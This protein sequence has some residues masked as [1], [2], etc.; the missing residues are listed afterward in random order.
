LK[1]QKMAILSDRRLVAAG[2]MLAFLLGGTAAGKVDGQTLS[3]KTLRTMARAY[4]AY[5]QYDKAQAL[6]EKAAIQSQKGQVE[7]GEQALCLIDL[8]TVYSYQD[9]LDDAAVMLAEGVRLQQQAIG[10][11]HPYTA[12]TLRMLSD[13]YRRQGNL[14]AAEDALGQ[15]FAVML[16]DTSIQSRQMTPFLM[17]A[18]QLCAAQGRYEAACMTFQVAEQMAIAAYGATHLYT[19]QVMQGA[20][21][22]A[23]ACGN[24]DYAQEQ[25]ERSVQIQERYWSN[26]PAMLIGGWLSKARISRACGALGESELYLRK[27]IAAAQQG[28]NVVALAGVYKQVNAIRAETLYTA[29][30]Q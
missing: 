27:A 25:I 14:S 19:A 6:A 15:A 5:G 18:A 3:T 9:M 7:L 28:R 10:A 4:M 23:M 17:A 30:V 2:L 12:H 1:G 8:G 21:E 22:A 20:A 16:A 13:V 24:L 26:N 29:A 11:D